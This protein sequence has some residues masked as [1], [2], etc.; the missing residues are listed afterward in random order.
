MGIMEK[1]METTRIL[2]VIGYIGIMEKEM[3]TI[4]ILGVTGAI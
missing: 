2:G 1:K 4:T 3:K